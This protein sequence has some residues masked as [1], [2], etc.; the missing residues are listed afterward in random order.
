MLR[1]CKLK[2]LPIKKNLKDKINKIVFSLKKE[3]CTSW[4]YRKKQII[5]RQVEVQ[6]QARWGPEQPGLVHGS[7]DGTKWSL[8]P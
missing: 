7:G 1:E 4:V 6:D 8:N 3:I 2:I 5:L